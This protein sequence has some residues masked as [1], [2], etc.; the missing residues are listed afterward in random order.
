MQL[1]IAVILDVGTGKVV[2]LAPGDIVMGWDDAANLQIPDEFVSPRH[3]IAHSSISVFDPT[4]D[5]FFPGSSINV[6][7]ILRAL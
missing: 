2:S 4:G 6:T 3:A 7:E 5:Q 1:Q